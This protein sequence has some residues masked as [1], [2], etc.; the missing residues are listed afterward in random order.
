[1]Q[2]DYLIIGQGISGTFLSFCLLERGARVL[3][4]D[5][6]QSHS[7]S[8]VAAGIMNPV[9]GRRLSTVWRANEIL[10]FVPEAYSAIGARLQGEAF[11]RKDIVDI[12]PNPFMRSSYEEKIAA[13]DPYVAL[14]ADV[15]EWE[16]WMQI[17]FG[18]GEIRP[19]HTAHLDWLIPAW[20]QYLQSRNMLREEAFEMQGLQVSADHIVYNDI[21]ASKIIFCEGPAGMENPWFRL[22]PF[23]KNKGQALILRIPDLPDYRI[24]KKSMLLVPLPEKEM[25]WLGASYEWEFEHVHPTHEFREK[26]E[27]ALKNWL[28]CEWTIEDQR[29]GLRPATLERRPFV[30][31]HPQQPAIGIFNG[32]GTKGCSLAPFFARELTVHLLDGKSISPEADVQRFRR[33]LSQN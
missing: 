32:M 17:E 33:I 24:Y 21:V 19:V 31:L 15:K 20:R 22:L 16:K 5:E 12:F 2:V 10:G 23:S 8:R 29:A 7:P 1:M 18:Y 13:A 27:L 4:I 26:T 11:S 14:G 30:G 9:T 28:R 6:P 25:F 3:V